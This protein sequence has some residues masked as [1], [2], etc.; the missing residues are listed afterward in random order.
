MA[1]SE[2]EVEGKARWGE[3]V[4]VESWVDGRGLKEW[5]DGHEIVSGVQRDMGWKVEIWRFERGCGAWGGPSEANAPRSEGGVKEVEGGEKGREVAVHGDGRVVDGVGEH[6]GGAVGSPNVHCGSHELDAGSG[7][8]E[9]DKAVGG[10]EVLGVVV[11]DDG[12]GVGKGEALAGTYCAGSITEAV[13][14]EGSGVAVGEDGVP[15]EWSGGGTDDAQVWIETRNVEKS[16][17]DLGNPVAP[18]A[19]EVDVVCETAGFRRE[20]VIG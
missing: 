4:S 10:G 11:Q 18:P 17:N 1:W 15:L 16:S 3:E 5:V 2:V 19:I 8:G 12:R 6:G 9:R 13:E 14:G 20:P 7:A